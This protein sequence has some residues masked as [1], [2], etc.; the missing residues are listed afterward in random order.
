MYVG[1]AVGGLAGLLLMVGAGLCWRRRRQRRVR[2]LGA[3][4]ATPFDPQG[5]DEIAGNEKDALLAWTPPNLSLFS[6]GGTPLRPSKRAMV[7]VTTDGPHSEASALA[8]SGASRNPAGMSASQSSAAVI[9]PPHEPS[10]AMQNLDA[11]PT[12]DLV[13]VLRTRMEAEVAEACVETLPAYVERQ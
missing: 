9:L 6:L 3:L 10:S 1:I 13:R 8:S 12:N 11:L 4:A 5:R 7:H 2:E